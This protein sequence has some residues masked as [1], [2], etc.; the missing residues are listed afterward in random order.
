MQKVTYLGI[1]L[2]H[3]K[4]WLEKN[5]KVTLPMISTIDEVAA[6]LKRSKNF[7]FFT[8]SNL[9]ESP[10]NELTNPEFEWTLRNEEKLK[11]SNLLRTKH[12]YS[13]P[14][15]IWRWHHE[16]KKIASKSQISNVHKR[17][18]DFQVFCAQNSKRCDI[19]TLSVDGHHRKAYEESFRTLRQLERRNLSKD[20]LPEIFE[21]E[22]DVQS[23]R[24]SEFCPSNSKPGVDYKL[25]EGVVPKCHDCGASSRP[26]I[27]FYDEKYESSEGYGVR[28]LMKRVENA[29]CV[30]VANLK[31]ATSL[32]LKFIDEA[33]KREIQV[34]EIS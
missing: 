32:E 26:H 25:S 15:E 1:Y 5:A 13:H 28:N 7:I 11:L 20:E 8:S 24:C 16:V 34:V 18:A 19:A 29:D 10:L 6:G 27:L 9:I 17:I 14:D 22:G 30:I 4:L 23:R 33:L 31:F 12:M 2:P 21:V 3:T